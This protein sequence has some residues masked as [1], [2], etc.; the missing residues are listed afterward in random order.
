MPG[1]LGFKGKRL[2]AYVHPLACLGNEALSLG[3]QQRWDELTA[4]GVETL[5]GDRCGAVKLAK[6]MTGGYCVFHAR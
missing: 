6:Q 2:R 3:G 4:E 1:L 5:R